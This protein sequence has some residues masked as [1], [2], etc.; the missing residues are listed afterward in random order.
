MVPICT[1]GVVKPMNIESPDQ[2]KGVFLVAQLSRI[3]GRVLENQLF[4]SLQK[5]LNEQKTYKKPEKAKK[6][7]FQFGRVL[8]QPC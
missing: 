4:D 2:G 5:A 8:L 1:E 3:A 7:V 6:L